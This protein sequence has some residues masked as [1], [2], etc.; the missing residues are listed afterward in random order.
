[1]S[2]CWR[3]GHPLAETCRIRFPGAESFLLMSTNL[4]RF[5]G[6]GWGGNLPHV[7]CSG[8]SGKAEWVS[9]RGQRGPFQ[10]LI[11]EGN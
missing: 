6:R 9:G 4:R 2:W 1:M 7:V 5:I 11:S 3:D 10:G 8:H